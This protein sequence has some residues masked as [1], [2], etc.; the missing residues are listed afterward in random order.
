VAREVDLRGVVR[1]SLF[2][3][4]ER[5]TVAGEVQGDVYSAGESFVLAP[6]GRIAR[7]ATVMADQVLLE[8][9]LGRDANALFA[10]R[11]EAR[12]SIGRDL[13]ARADRL[14]LL[15]S[16]RIGRNVEAALPEGVSLERRPGAQVGGEL[17]EVALETQGGGELR[18]YLEPEI[19][20][21]MLLHVGSGFVLGMLLH[22]LAPGILAVRAES[23]RDLLRGLGIGLATLVAVPLA[24][25]FAAATVVGIPVALI[26]AAALATALYIG[27]VAVGALIGAALLHPSEGSRGAFGAALATGLA[28]LVILTH[29]PFLGDA[30][31]A[32]AI[33]V[34]LGLLVERA[35]AAWRGREVPA[36]P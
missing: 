14:V 1:G 15:E 5:S 20:A 30:L 4:G 25:A 35:L 26:G 32:V 2:V 31:R 8:G 16:A 23:P 34:G 24:L 33:V 27:L 10:E 12:G 11:I 17:R 21:W 18:R 6:G 13:R 19:Y 22:L 9:E 7:D 28:V 29:L 36:A 3:A